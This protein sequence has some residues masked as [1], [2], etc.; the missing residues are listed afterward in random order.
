MTDTQPTTDDIVREGQCEFCDEFVADDREMVEDQWG[1]RYC[2][3]CCFDEAREE[4][5]ADWR[6]WRTGGGHYY[7]LNL[8]RD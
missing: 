5:D 2:S 1:H 6:E 3:D 8:D 7:D 4:A